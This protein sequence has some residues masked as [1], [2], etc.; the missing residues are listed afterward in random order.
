M[1]V[2]VEKEIEKA[3]LS[4]QETSLQLYK[5]GKSISEIAQERNMANSTIEG[6]LAHF[7]GLGELS[8]NGLVDPQK[9][10]LITAYIEE[11]KGKQLSEIR[12]ALGN[13]Y[14]YSE[15]RFVL[16]NMEANH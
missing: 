10:K 7:V 4:S 3:G 13:E 11:K 14:S 15:I 16:K 12:T 1:P 9:V 5:S 2:G 6:H 8:L